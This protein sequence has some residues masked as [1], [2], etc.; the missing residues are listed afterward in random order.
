MRP[1]DVLLAGEA[2]GEVLV[3]DAPLSFWG[4]VHEST[5]EVTD[6]HHPQHGAS[7][8]GRVMLLPGGRGSSSSSSVLAE[9]IRGG[10]GP[11]A[12]LLGER[13]PII[14]LGAMVAEALYGRC[15]PVLV[16]DGY[17]YERVRTWRRVRIARTADGVV[18]HEGARV[19]A[20]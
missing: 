9:V 14:A 2:E 19:P 16:L 3:L 4:G 11:A 15:V 18:L 8:A 7:V 10:V 1:A 5:G 12:I 17:D 6:T 20:P 13:D